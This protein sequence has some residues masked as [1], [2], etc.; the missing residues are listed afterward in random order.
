MKFIVGNV[1]IC[2]NNTSYIGNLIVI[3]VYRYSENNKII[4]YFT[5]SNSDFSTSKRML[6]YVD[7]FESRYT[8]IDEI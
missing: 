7:K 6:E 2:T 5:S 1:Y 3:K 4:E 8:I